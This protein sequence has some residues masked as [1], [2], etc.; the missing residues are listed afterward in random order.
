MA[1]GGEGR[2]EAREGRMVV[3]WGEARQAPEIA[4]VTE[5]SSGLW[6]SGGEGGRWGGV[7]V[8]GR[9]D[10]SRRERGGQAHLGCS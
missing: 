4:R 5:Q 10:S 3:G 1:Q 2:G 6:V 9:R 7:V 8:M